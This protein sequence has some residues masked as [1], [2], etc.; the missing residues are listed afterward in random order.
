MTSLLEP[1]EQG[2]SL[3]AILDRAL[4]EADFHVIPALYADQTAKARHERERVYFIHDA[5]SEEINRVA[6]E[7]A[8]L[9]ITNPSLQIRLINGSN[10]KFGLVIAH[11]FSGSAAELVACIGP[12]L[13]VTRSLVRGIFRWLF[14]DLDLRRVT[15]RIP[16]SNTKA[17]EAATRLRFKYEGRQR[18]W[19][20]DDEDVLLFG[21]LRSECPAYWLRN[22]ADG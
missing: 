5:N 3:G 19:L 16:A 22:T 1:E 17:V 7:W 4:A 2:E 13:P 10:T 11:S 15:L 20:A 12:G 21:M 6:T 18:R 9:P 8:H 14:Q